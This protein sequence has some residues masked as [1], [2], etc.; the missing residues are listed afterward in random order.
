MASAAGMSSAVPPS[1]FAVLLR[2]SKFASYDPRIGQVWT[3]FGGDAARGNWGLKRPLPLRK[4]AAHISISAVDTKEQQT[5]WKH[6][7]TSR[8]FVKMWDEVGIQPKTRDENTPRADLVDSDFV[9]KEDGAKP[10]TRN[11]A[12][13]SKESYA[14]P[15]PEAMS[16]RQFQTYLRRL[17]QMR[18]AFREFVKQTSE[19]E[20]GYASPPSL[21][22]LKRLAYEY[23]NAP[24]S[25][26]IE[27]QPAPSGGLSYRQTPPLQSFYDTKP[28][29]GHVIERAYGGKEGLAG[30]AG[31]N[32][33]LPFDLVK[34]GSSK[35]SPT[36]IQWEELATTGVRVPDEGVAEFRVATAVLEQKPIVV[37]EKPSGV[38]A[39]KMV[40]EVAAPM[41]KREQ[42]NPHRPGTR[43]YVGY[44]P[45]LTPSQQGNIFKKVKEKVQVQ[46]QKPADVAAEAMDMFRQ[47][48][49]DKP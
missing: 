41:P 5:V 29:K 30:F 37:G 23:Y 4:R 33:L 7:G 40:A 48:L 32:A 12:V 49:K 8:R 45:N 18:P 44:L 28:Q 36:A 6:A 10:W 1:Q 35:E 11:N 25:R 26:A 13:A 42:E 43:E 19:E 21:D 38:E 9:T 46:G 2:R 17:R 15:N 39:M 14:L 20:N 22:F 47:L 24:E 31:V 34:D 16:D 3:T 27:Q